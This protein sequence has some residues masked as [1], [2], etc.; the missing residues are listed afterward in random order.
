MK[1]EK[2]SKIF[3]FAVLIVLGIL[4]AIFG[5]GAIDVYL[6]IVACIAGVVVLADTLFLVSRKEKVVATP[7]VIASAFLAIGIALFVHWIS[8][9]AIV[10][11]LVVVILGAGVGLFFYGIYLLAK[12][13][14]SA[15]L[16]N[17][18]VGVIAIVLAVL[19]M[20]L[21]KFREIF[22]IIVGIVI[23]VYGLLGLIFTLIDKKNK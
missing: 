11:F 1:N 10:N 17:V 2:L 4:I 6:G 14:Q 21:P 18:V 23:A 3:T 5:T 20:A 12:K 15:G 22:W 16:L 19:Y 8:F 13:E 7:F 9:A